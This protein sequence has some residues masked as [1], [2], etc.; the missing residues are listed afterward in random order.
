MIITGKVSFF[1]LELQPNHLSLRETSQHTQK[2]ELIPEKPRLKAN[3]YDTEGCVPVTTTLG[4]SKGEE[5]F[6]Q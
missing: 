5:A 4:W 2:S 3:L 1:T 6:V